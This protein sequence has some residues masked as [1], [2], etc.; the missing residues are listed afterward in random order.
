MLDIMMN[1][2]ES[3]LIVG[4]GGCGKTSLVLDKLK[5]SCSGDLS[6]LFYITINTNR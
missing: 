4:E 2:D 3:F 5:T 6:D 1:L